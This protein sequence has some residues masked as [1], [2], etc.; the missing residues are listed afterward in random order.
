MPD[1]KAGL[2]TLL[3]S[4]SPRGALPP[5]VGPDTSSYTTFNFEFNNLMDTVRKI[6]DSNPM[7]KAQAGQPTD[8]AEPSIR[9]VTATL[10]NQVHVAS[11]VSRPI[12]EDSA[13]MVWAVQCTKPQE[14][15]SL[16][17]QWAAQAGMES[18]DF[19][20]Q[21]IYSMKPEMMGMLPIGG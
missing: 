15:E 18:R 21:R 4:A 20:G 10:G 14:F 3:D 12:K 7:L 2:T 16:I 19:L 8:Q 13:H 11:S 5:F 1:G 6:V 17:Q 9:Q